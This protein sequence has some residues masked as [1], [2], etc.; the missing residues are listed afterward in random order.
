MDAH[1][2][3]ATGNQSGSTLLQHLFGLCGNAVMLE[4][5]ES[6]GSYVVMEGHQIIRAFSPDINFHD[7]G[8]V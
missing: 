7:K 6:H 2:F 8:L 3:I 5:Q 4:Q 1:D